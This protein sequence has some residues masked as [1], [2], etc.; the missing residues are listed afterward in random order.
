[1]VYIWF[2]IW[3]LIWFIL[4][5]KE[6]TEIFIKASGILFFWVLFMFIT[7]SLISVNDKDITENYKA[8]NKSIN[9]L[10]NIV[11]QIQLD[12]QKCKKVKWFMNFNTLLCKNW[13]AYIKESNFNDVVIS[14]QD[15]FQEYSKIHNFKNFRYILKFMKDKN[16]SIEKDFLYYKPNKNVKKTVKK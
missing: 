4:L 5:T 8:Y 14:L 7:I 2:C 15:Y 12:V 1:M 9:N 3:I 6:W 10:W 11:S 16:M 13:Q